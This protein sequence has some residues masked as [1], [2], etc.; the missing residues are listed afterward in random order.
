MP[1]E[2]GEA[3]HQP[4]WPNFFKLIQFPQLPSGELFPAAKRRTLHLAVKWH[5][6]ARLPEPLKLFTDFSQPLARLR[7][8]LEGYR[9]KTLSDSVLRRRP[10]EI[11]QLFGDFGIFRHAAESY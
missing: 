8:K 9:S 1:T 11:K 4:R 3:I 7:R 10:I 2:R 6:L 5:L